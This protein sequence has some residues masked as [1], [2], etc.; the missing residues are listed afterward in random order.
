MEDKEDILDNW[1][2]YVIYKVE[3]WKGWSAAWLFIIWRKLSENEICDRT[4]KSNMKIASEINGIILKGKYDIE[5][6]QIIAVLPE[7]EH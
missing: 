4:N 7:H 3:K 1:L 5:D 6:Y 2:Q